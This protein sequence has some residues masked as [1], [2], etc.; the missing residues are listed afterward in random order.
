M[1]LWSYIRS[2]LT[3]LPVPSTDAEMREAEADI[4]A[5]ALPEA[6]RR[7]RAWVGKGR[8]CLGAGG[9][10]PEAD[11]PWSTCAK[12]T[13]H[14][15][16]PAGRVFC[17]C[18][19]FVCFVHR[20]ARHDKTAGVWLNTDELEVRGKRQGIAWINARPGDIVSYGAGKAIGHCGIVSEVDD[21]G[22]VRV[23]HCQARGTVAVVETSADLFERKGAVLWRPS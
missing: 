14:G 17:D 3:P 6:V 23:I 13:T 18:S 2:L 4:E 10:K 11:D 19:G 8:Y 12:P 21:A 20:L 22:P 7:A 16:T 15:H 5:D 9:K 1:S